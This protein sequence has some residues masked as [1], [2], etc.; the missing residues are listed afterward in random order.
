MKA[1]T[2][3]EVGDSV[4]LRGTDGPVMVVCEIVDEDI[5][6]CY[7]NG[8]GQLCRDRINSRC[9]NK[10]AIHLRSSTC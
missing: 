1:M 8:S 3:F 10:L 4:V 5:K 7:F 6:V 2:I 9:V